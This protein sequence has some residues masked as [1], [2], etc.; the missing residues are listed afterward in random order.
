MSTYLAHHLP[1]AHTTMQLHP[2]LLRDS[3]IPLQSV[4]FPASSIKITYFY[5]IDCVKIVM[6]NQRDLD[7]SLKNEAFLAGDIMV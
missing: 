7:N 1:D 6:A 3:G 4:T 2:G 5:S